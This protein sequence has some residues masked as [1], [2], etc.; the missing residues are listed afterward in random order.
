MLPGCS[1]CCTPLRAR[2]ESLPSRY[3]AL[4]RP[5]Y[6]GIDSAA[7][8]QR[9]ILGTLKKACRVRR[10]TQ[11]EHGPRCDSND[12]LAATAL[13]RWP[14]SLATTRRTSSPMLGRREHYLAGSDEA[15]TS[16]ENP[17]FTAPSNFNGSKTS[18][19]D[20][21]GDS[22]GDKLDRQSPYYPISELD[23]VSHKNIRQ[24][25]NLLYGTQG[26]CDAPWLSGYRKDR[27]ELVDITQGMGNNTFLLYCRNPKLRPIT[28]VRVVWIDASSASPNRTSDT[29]ASQSPGSTAGS[30]EARRSL[31]SGWHRVT[32]AL[33]VGVDRTTWKSLLEP[34]KLGYLEFRRDFGAAPLY[35]I[36]FAYVETE[37]ILDGFTVLDADLIPPIPAKTYNQDITK[38]SGRARAG[39]QR[40]KSSSSTGAHG[41][42]TVMRMIALYGDWPEGLVDCGNQKQSREA[43]SEHQTAPD[44]DSTA[45]AVV[46][47]DAGV[48]TIGA[49]TEPKCARAVHSNVPIPWDS[50]PTFMISN[51][52][53]PATPEV[54]GGPQWKFRC[55]P[56]SDTM[57]SIV[58][59]RVD[60]PAGWSNDL[61]VTWKASVQVLPATDAGKDNQSGEQ[62]LDLPPQQ[63]VDRVSSQQI[64]PAVFQ[65]IA[66]LNVGHSRIPR[67]S[68]EIEGWHPL[69]NLIVDA[70]FPTR[71]YVLEPIWRD[72]HA[73]LYVSVRLVDRRMLIRLSSPVV[74]RNT[75]DFPL[76]ICCQHTLN[77]ETEHGVCEAGATFPLPVGV[78]D[79]YQF[80]EIMVPLHIFWHTKERTAFYTIHPTEIRALKSTQWVHRGV[81]GYVYR[82]SVPGTIKLWGRDGRNVAKADGRPVMTTNR[83]RTK[84]TG[85]FPG[86]KRISDVELIR[87]GYREL[88]FIYGSPQPKCN[89]L[90]AWWWTAGSDIVFAVEMSGPAPQSNSRPGYTFIGFEGFLPG[91]Y[92]MI[93]VKPI[94]PSLSALARRQ[95]H[96]APSATSSLPAAASSTVDLPGAP[97]DHSRDDSDVGKWGW[98]K[99]DF[100]SGGFN[101]YLIRRLFSF[102][103]DQWRPLYFGCE[104]TTNDECPAEWLLE[105]PVIIKNSLPCS[106]YVAVSM[107]SDEPPGSSCTTIRPNTSSGV[108]CFGCPSGYGSNGANL[109]YPQSKHF[110][111]VA[112]RATVLTL[113]SK[114]VAEVG[115]HE[116]QQ[117]EFRTE[118]AA[119]VVVV[120]AEVPIPVDLIRSGDAAIEA[121]ALTSGRDMGSKQDAPE[122]T[123][124]TKVISSRQFALQVV[125]VDRDDG[126]TRPI[127]VAW[128]IS[129]TEDTGSPQISLGDWCVKPVEVAMPSTRADVNAKSKAT[130]KEAERV[131]G[132]NPDSET[133]K[134][135]VAWSDPD[136]TEY[137]L[138]LG[139]YQRA[140]YSNGK[141]PLITELYCPYLI[142]NR[143]GMDLSLEMN[144]ADRALWY[145]HD[146]RSGSS[147]QTPART[148]LGGR[149]T[150]TCPERHLTSVLGLYA[151]PD[152]VGQKMQIVLQQSREP[153]SHVLL[154][155]LAPVTN[156]FSGNTISYSTTDAAS[157]LVYEELRLRSESVALDDVSGLQRV[158]LCMDETSTDISSDVGV[159]ASSPD[160]GSGGTATNAART[161]NGKPQNPHCEVCVYWSWGSA[162]RLWRV[163]EICPTAAFI[164]RTSRP[165]YVGYSASSDA[166]LRSP[167][168]LAS[169]ELTDVTRIEPG[170]RLPCNIAITE[171][172]AWRARFSQSCWS[173]PLPVGPQ[174]YH[175]VAYV[176]MLGATG[177]LELSRVEFTSR[178]LHREITFYPPPK[179][180][181]IEI[182]NNCTTAT[183]CFWQ[184][185]EDNSHVRPHRYLLEPG[186]KMGYAFDDYSGKAPLQLSFTVDGAV[187]HSTGPGNHEHD[188]PGAT[189]SLVEKGPFAFEYRRINS[190]VRAGVA[191]VTALM[192]EQE[193]SWIICLADS[194]AECRAS[195]GLQRVP[196]VE[197]PKLR[198]AIDLA[199]LGLSIVNEATGR[200]VPDEL[201]YC[202]VLGIGLSITRTTAEIRRF[203]TVTSIQVDHQMR[204]A[205][206][207]VVLR[208]RPSKDALPAPALQLSHVS[209]LPQLGVGPGYCVDQEL[210]AVISPL[211]LKIDDVFLVTLDRIGAILS[212]ATQ[213]GDES[214]SM[215]DY[216][217]SARNG[218]SERVSVADSGQQVSRRTNSDA[219]QHQQSRIHFFEKVELNAVDV[220]VT[221]SLVESP[222]L[223]KYFATMGLASR[224]ALVTLGRVSDMQL[225]KSVQHFYPYCNRSE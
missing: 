180:P 148:S 36:D 210:I 174:I 187:A 181:P 137:E 10:H 172:Q 164:N 97:R 62:D 15:A 141:G 103:R 136:G 146:G 74:I 170:G 88:G 115:S 114:G 86:Q 124:N 205:V 48:A 60:V 38:Q 126:W 183:L 26:G 79:S 191:G 27:R 131:A 209:R 42:P 184:H 85:G 9:L 25:P 109:A 65:A 118:A 199:G 190:S 106:I 95:S 140:K 40:L 50:Q 113:V 196:G 161:K 14:T 19:G 218:T 133:G 57:F 166:R 46:F 28:A 160:A 71:I 33:N 56:I 41:E 101:P 147:E 67:I 92:G 206:F 107:S 195:L 120:E 134:I 171:K 16:T 105:A 35:E 87:A 208:R 155:R 154:P 80:G 162:D 34:T 91:H 13:S 17:M 1:Q 145:P 182:R 216:S 168:L 144:I 135:D 8:D 186:V 52:S 117:S 64:A 11:S 151:P 217:T 30:H 159:A 194:V 156:K 214:G 72:C 76:K 111:W 185:L 197:R 12:W 179:T 29:S 45:P 73:R 143:T 127:Y 203:A 193:Q 119:K 149:S 213:K 150:P 189:I 221:T 158:P 47:V 121:R 37:R 192:N 112:L 138:R 43:S 116:L 32:P 108:S 129:T 123:F 225:R 157:E 21:L 96:R 128:E 176:K 68:I 24:N 77:D 31:E 177:R 39:K 75:F 51:I 4:L 49:S 98:S 165:I 5:L 201:V 23:I 89:G 90:A 82:S 178:G 175:R 58:A 163:V 110:L 93:R 99:E 130:S 6:L 44:G 204:D 211:E 207:D 212:S 122:F 20:T 66:V 100:A 78:A 142:A 59:A 55:E 83:A 152:T 223:R 222:Y 94:V 215:V 167:Y 202:S 18:Y 84:L 81:L 169:A 2:N 173:T 198:M 102:L 63:F 139:V 219:S 69:S 61:T 22:H 54:V 3:F 125:R 188:G 70:E 132:G 200:N 53:S 153:L 220:Y 224:S 7:A 104:V